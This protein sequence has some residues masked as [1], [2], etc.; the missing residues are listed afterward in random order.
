M[1]KLGKAVVGLSPHSLRLARQL[2]TLLSQRYT[3][4]AYFFRATQQ[5]TKKARKKLRLAST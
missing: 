2:H 4:R 3:Y 1:G 5:E